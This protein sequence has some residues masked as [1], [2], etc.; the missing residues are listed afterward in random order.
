MNKFITGL[1]IFVCG[2]GM[3]FYKALIFSYYWGWFV[4]PFGVA[5]ISIIHC[6]GLLAIHGLM[7]YNMMTDNA[8]E[9]EPQEIFLNMATGFLVISF[10][11]G[12]GW[13]VSKYM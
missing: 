12:I 10:A 7:S 6:Y 9:E 2:M 13:I 5:Q 3:G 1:S 11:F 4:T 8:K